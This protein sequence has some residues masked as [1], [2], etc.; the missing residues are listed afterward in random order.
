[1]GSF[2]ALATDLRH[3]SSVLADGLT[4]LTTDFRHMFT[5][6]ADGLASFS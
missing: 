6:L 5:I 1:M 2:A 4:A 3:V